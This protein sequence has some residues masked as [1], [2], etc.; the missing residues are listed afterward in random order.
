MSVFHIFKLF[1][2]TVGLI[3]TQNA[4]ARKN[5]FDQ[6]SKQTRN[7]I[8]LRQRALVLELGLCS[9]ILRFFS[10]SCY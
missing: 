7:R 5:S 4:D 10:L 1:P 9:F 6:T 8:K 3:A 2:Q